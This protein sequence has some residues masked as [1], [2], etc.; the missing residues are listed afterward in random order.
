MYRIKIPILAVIVAIMMLHLYSMGSK[1]IVEPLG[2]S[3]S[4]KMIDSQPMNN[5]SGL[6]FPSY[7]D[8]KYIYAFI[9]DGDKLNYK[10]YDIENGKEININLPKNKNLF[11]C[12]EEKDSDRDHWNENSDLASLNLIGEKNLN[13]ADWSWHSNFIDLNLKGKFAEPVNDGSV[14]S[15]RSFLKEIERERF[16]HRYFQFFGENKGVEK[17]SLVYGE[18]IKDY[19]KIPVTINVE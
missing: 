2:Y 11:I 12:I 13:K 15:Y 1:S 17:I 6:V 7:D 18:Q 4:V 5:I 8:K 16:Q 19:I 10:R 3:G 9:L 14:Y